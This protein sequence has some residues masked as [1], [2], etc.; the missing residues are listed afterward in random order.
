M[1]SG[2]SETKIRHYDTLLALLSQNSSVSRLG[3]STA[4]GWATF[5]PDPYSELTQQ[6][7]PYSAAA[8]V[9][10]RRRRRQQLWECFSPA[11]DAASGLKK[12]I[13]VGL[14]CR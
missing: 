3:K 14:G 5:K 7:R 8:R 4:N 2:S 10:P 6:S 11:G 13:E 1:S 12:D 9:L